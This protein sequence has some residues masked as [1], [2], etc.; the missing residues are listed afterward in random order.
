L[1]V[2]A[3]EYKKASKLKED[4][5]KLEKEIVDMKA[6]FTIPKKE[7]LTITNEDVQ[8]ILSIST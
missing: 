1:A 8:K 7:R 5:I 4:Q 6:K 2:I 3:Q